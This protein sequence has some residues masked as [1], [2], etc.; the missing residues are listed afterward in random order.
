MT[1]SCS[2]CPQTALLSSPRYLWVLN[3]F[4]IS[5][6]F[7]VTYFEAS[8]A[9]SFLALTLPPQE[10]TNP[11][12]PCPCTSI[13]LLVMLL[14]PHLPALIPFSLKYNFTDVT[15]TFHSRGCQNSSG[16]SISSLHGSQALSQFPRL[17]GCTLWIITRS[18]WTTL[19][20]A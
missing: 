16:N 9:A 19:S 7:L 5:K 17:T 1:N 8:H 11:T 3:C 4:T 15:D 10:Q 18:I 20:D 12:L 2:V 14:C 13:V 6:I